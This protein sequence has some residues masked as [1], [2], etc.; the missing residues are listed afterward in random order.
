MRLKLLTQLEAFEEVGPQAYLEMTFLQASGLLGA[1]VGGWGKLG[2]AACAF[3]L[4]QGV[5]GQ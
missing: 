5:A 3:G 2:A 4:F 1:A